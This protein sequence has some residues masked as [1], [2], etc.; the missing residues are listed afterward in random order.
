MRI[1]A[2]CLCLAIGLPAVPALA[3][4]PAQ[5]GG[6]PQVAV[7][8][9]RLAAAREVIKAA[10]GDRMAV[11]EAMKPPMIG[12]VQ[13]MGLKDRDK[14]QV[15]VSEVVMPTLAEHYDELVSI[16]ALAFA[17]VLSKEDLQAVAAF[18]G[19]PAGRNLVKAQP[20][21]A[22]ALLTGMRQW[23]GSIGPELQTKIA[24]AAEAHGWTGGTAK[25]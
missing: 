19:T 2:I 6:V 15:M 16:Q 13:Q 14:A 22:Q 20:Q 1:A 25:P 18:Y 12:M 24:K 10:Q 4:A 21:F 3:E 17:A 11:L 8:P 5:P 7:D 23:M 9:E